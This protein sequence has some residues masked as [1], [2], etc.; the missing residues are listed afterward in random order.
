VKV[1]FLCNQLNNVFKSNE[2]VCLGIY[3]LWQI[4]L[5]NVVAY[6]VMHPMLSDSG[7]ARWNIFIWWILP[8]FEIII[9]LK[10]TSQY[11][12]GMQKPGRAIFQVQCHFYRHWTDCVMD[13][14]SESNMIGSDLVE[15]A[16]HH[17]IKL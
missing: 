17:H 10:S 16:R 8:T 14:F 15:S 1:S 12:T 11:L 2:G 4:M 9:W 6:M 3:H 7:S 5:V 13:T